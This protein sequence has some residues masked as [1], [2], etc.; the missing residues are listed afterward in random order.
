MFNSEFYRMCDQL[1]EELA[2]LYRQYP[3]LNPAMPHHALNGWVRIGREATAAV[4]EFT[5]ALAGLAQA[6]S[7]VKFQ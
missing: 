2:S 7:G 4:Q 6:V 3:D 1:H 5:K